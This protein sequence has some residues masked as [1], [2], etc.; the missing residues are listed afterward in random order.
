MFDQF[1]TT[2]QAA[3]SGIGVAL[4]PG[5]LLHEEFASSKLVAA[6]DLSLKISRPITRAG[7]MPMPANPPLAAFKNCITAEVQVEKN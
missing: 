4:L 5:F 6:L 1:A 7:P 3:I 2:T